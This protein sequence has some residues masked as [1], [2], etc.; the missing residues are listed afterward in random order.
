MSER[1]ELNVSYEF[2]DNGK[3]ELMLVFAKPDDEDADDDNAKLIY[4]GISK[5]ILIRNENQIINIPDIP[6]TVREMLKRLDII[7]V[8]EM[9]GEDI[10]DVYEAKIQLGGSPLTDW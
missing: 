8:T 1:E 3:D 4:D 7:L 9:D 2:I 5:A 10:N 6:V